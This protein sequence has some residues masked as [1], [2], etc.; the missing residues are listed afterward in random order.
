MVS[1]VQRSFCRL[2]IRRVCQARK[3]C[4]SFLF[5][6]LTFDATSIS[7]FSFITNFLKKQMLPSGG[8]T[9]DEFSDTNDCFCCCIYLLKPALCVYSMFCS[10]TSS[11]S[12]D[13]ACLFFQTEIKLLQL[14]IIVRAHDV[15]RYPTDH[16]RAVIYS[17][18]YFSM[19]ALVVV[20]LEMKWKGAENDP[21]A[22]AV[23]RLSQ[24]CVHHVSCMLVGGCWA[25]T[26]K[27]HFPNFSFRVSFSQETLKDVIIMKLFC[28]AAIT[29]HALLL[30]WTLHTL[31]AEH[32]LWMIA[33]VFPTFS[34]GPFGLCSKALVCVTS[35]SPRLLPLLLLQ[36][37]M[38]PQ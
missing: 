12:N 21:L 32:R 11:F 10:F 1:T 14:N 28:P 13:F 38:L 26:S 9:A 4:C 25:A 8:T 22:E 29:G 36:L 5:Q 2:K 31:T 7:F 3:E 20:I 17:V 19:G 27:I 6:K 18:I 37:H 34:D 35:S 16:N 30:T 33:S 24:A 23:K 15:C